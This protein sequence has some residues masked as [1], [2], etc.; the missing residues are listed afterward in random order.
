MITLFSGPKPFAGPIGL[1]QDNAIGSWTRLGEGAE[2]LLLGE[3]TGI[4]E[5]AERHG[6]RH[7]PVG[8]R[9]GGG[10]GAARGGR[11]R[12][13]AAAAPRREAAI[14]SCS[15]AHVTRRCLRSPSVAP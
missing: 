7:I 5:A 2:V 9:A 8:P 10:G 1:I 11:G 15:R 12:G 4:R 6:G 13:R 3:E 14:I